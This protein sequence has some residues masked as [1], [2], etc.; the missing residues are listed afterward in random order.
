MK[1][2][3]IELGL[4]GDE[5]WPKLSIVHV[6]GVPQ[7]APIPAA[8]MDQAEAEKVI[9]SW[10]KTAV[11]KVTPADG[12]ALVGFWAASDACQYLNVPVET[13]K[14]GLFAMRIGGS[15]VDFFALSQ[16]HKTNYVLELVE[17]TG[18]EN[19]KYSHIAVY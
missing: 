8:G 19:P 11:L 13:T 2:R 18:I 17:I 6:P 1:L 4:E 7:A 14:D 12:G 3:K 5:F 16:N 9:R 15:D 10:D